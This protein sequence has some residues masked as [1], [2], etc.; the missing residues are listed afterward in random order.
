MDN[1]LAKPK[2]LFSPQQKKCGFLSAAYQQ[3]PVVDNRPDRL[4]KNI[5]VSI[6]FTRFYL[7]PRFFKSIKITDGP[8]HGFKRE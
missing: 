7:N 5:M 3:M 4:D 6:G 2:T 1:C 8:V